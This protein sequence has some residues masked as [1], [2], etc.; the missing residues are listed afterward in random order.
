M[1]NLK[2]GLI[3]LGMHVAAYGGLVFLLEFIR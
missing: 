2:F 3:V 1:S